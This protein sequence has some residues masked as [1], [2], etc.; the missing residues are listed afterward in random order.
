MHDPGESHFHLLRAFARESLLLAAWRH[1]D[2]SG[3]RQHAFG[4]ATLLIST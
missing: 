3:Y 2:A 1:A 4:D